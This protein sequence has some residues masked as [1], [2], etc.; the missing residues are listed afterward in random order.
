M[1]ARIRI[2]YRL[3]GFILSAIMIFYAASGTIMTF[4]IQIIS[5]RKTHR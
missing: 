5:K 3:S 4:G 2:L 1:I